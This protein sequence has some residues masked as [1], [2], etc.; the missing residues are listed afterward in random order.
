MTEKGLVALSQGIS[1]LSELNQLS[2][3][4]R[5]VANLTNNGMEKFS[6]IFPALRDLV[7]LRIDFTQCKAFTDECFTKMVTYLH[8]LKNLQ[9]I[10][11]CFKE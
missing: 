5:G 2:I 11:L 4:F 8:S 1:Q 9:N 3:N 6:L 7:D 10:K